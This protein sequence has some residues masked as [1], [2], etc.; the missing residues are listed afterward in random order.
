[1]DEVS[2]GSKVTANFSLMEELKN[3]SIVAANVC[4]GRCGSPDAFFE[5]IDMNDMMK[6]PNLQ[7]TVLDQQGSST[8]MWGPVDDLK[9][10]GECL[11]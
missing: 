3:D 8:C 1:M 7:I 4:T 11:R 10:M 5:P 9:H 2:K 6:I